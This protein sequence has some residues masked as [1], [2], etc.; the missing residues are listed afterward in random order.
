MAIL[1]KYSVVPAYTAMELLRYWLTKLF[2][3]CI[4]YSNTIIVFYCIHLFSSFPFIKTLKTHYKI[5]IFYG[6]N[7]FI[8]LLFKEK[9]LK[10]PC[11]IF[12]KVEDFS[13]QFLIFNTYAIYLYLKYL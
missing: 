1:Y 2:Y 10:I 3:H 11:V 8:L 6:F 12:L 9:M 7:L 5:L 4:Y 13:T